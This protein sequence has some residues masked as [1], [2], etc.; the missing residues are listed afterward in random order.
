MPDGGL[1]LINRKIRNALR[2]GAVEG[3]ETPGAGIRNDR[4]AKKAARHFECDG[5]YYD[6]WEGVFRFKS[7]WQIAANDACGLVG[8][9][10]G[11][12]RYPFDF[13]GAH[14]TVFRHEG[15]GD[16]IVGT[17]IKQSEF[18]NIAFAPVLNKTS[19]AEIKLTGRSNKNL[20]SRLLFNLPYRAMHI[21]DSVYTD[22]EHSLVYSPY[23]DAAFYV[24]GN[25][26]TLSSH[27]EKAVFRR[28]NVYLTQRAAPQPSAATFKNYANSLAV[29][30]GDYTEVNGYMWQA[31]QAG[32]TASSGGGPVPPAG[33]IYSQDR[34]GVF[35]ADGSVI[36]G[37]YG[38]TFV[39]A[40]MADSG[41]DYMIVDDCESNAASAVKA[42]NTFGG[43]TAPKKLHVRNSHFDH[44]MSHVIWVAAACKEFKIHHNDAEASARGTGI[45]VDNA[46]A[47]NFQIT[48]N[49]LAANAGGNKTI[50]PSINGTTR[51]YERNIEV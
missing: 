7:Q 19:G 45:C 31:T 13:S 48:E 14:G 24:T 28:T 12:E 1:T 20:F 41:G 30:L 5:G 37:W 44:C 15:Q 46:S 26:S 35:V 25:P 23:G 50:V 51:I 6:G 36:W 2:E 39:T 16:F 3:D 9:N 22:V 11:Y 32:T 27:T 4:I 42:V 49:F 43:G 33:W 29:S 8:V 40:F 47:D 21:E 38:R 18:R 10:M 34:T 17:G